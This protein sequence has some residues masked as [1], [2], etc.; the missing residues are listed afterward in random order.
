M[1]MPTRR[2]EGSFGSGLRETKEYNSENVSLF[3]YL[4]QVPTT[5]RRESEMICTAKLRKDEYPQNQLD[6]NAYN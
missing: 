2:K 6:Q 5:S 1:E 3:S 4:Y